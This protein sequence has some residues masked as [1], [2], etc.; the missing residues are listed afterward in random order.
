[1]NEDDLLGSKLSPVPSTS[2]IVR[3][4]APLAAVVLVMGA[5]SGCNPGEDPRAVYDAG[6]SVN[7]SGAP[8]VDG[9]FDAGSPGVIFDAG[10]SPPDAGTD[11]AVPGVDGSPPDTGVDSG[12]SDVP[13]EP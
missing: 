4:G 3:A 1:M 10:I 9:G 5:M 6:L 12:V 8:G 13:P 11:S 7:D 2:P